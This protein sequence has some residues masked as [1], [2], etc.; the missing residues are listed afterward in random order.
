MA[1]KELC[2]FHYHLRKGGVCDVI[3]FSLRAIIKYL[4]HIK[5]INVISGTNENFD[6]IKG[7]LQDLNTN[8]IS[9]VVE[10]LI[11]YQDAQE[12][13]P[14]SQEITSM[15]QAYSGPD[16]LWWIHNYHLGKNTS[17]TQALLNWA[18]QG[19][20]L[21]FQ[22]HD[23]PECARYEN[24]KNIT[25]SIQDE[26]Y[27]QGK[28]IRYALINHRDYKLLG[29]GGI[30]QEELFLLDN[31]VPLGPTVQED[32]QAIKTEMAQRWGKRFP[33]FQAKGRLFLYPVRAIRRKNLLEAALITMLQDD[34]ANLVVTLPGVSKGEIQYSDFCRQ[35]FLEGVIPGMFGLGMEEDQGLLNYQNYWAAADMLLSSSIQEGFG[36]LYLNSLHWQKPLMAR[37]LDILGGM[38]D[39]LKGDYSLFY[40]EVKVPLQTSEKSRILD[41]YQIKLNEL[42]PYLG[43]ERIARRFEEL[44]KAMKMDQ[45]DFSYLSMELQADIL[46]RIKTDSS[47]RQ[48]TKTLN[49]DLISK[50]DT[51]LSG[52]VP[53][54]DQEIGKRFG[55]ESYARNLKKILKS[56]EQELEGISEA[57]NM[58]SFLSQEFSTLPY[59]R[60]L[61]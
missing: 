35:L 20:S 2:I 48:A 19:Q 25:E 55:E 49:Q 54:L 53:N 5:K 10:P 15:L 18:A 52:S 14:E 51:L 50:M 56:F 41:S 9:L 28:N 34:P 40:H 30:S 13:K 47:Y 44:S 21:L 43:R 45:L 26:I 32:P 7:K 37:Y 36:Y 60:L 33:S 38:E 29:K 11:N 31:P 59:L 23:F 57:Q 58:Q 46:K 39:I 17:F 4:P 1:F 8:R 6:Y 16:R 22:I 3:L 27:P 42:Q 24:L 12:T 61:Y